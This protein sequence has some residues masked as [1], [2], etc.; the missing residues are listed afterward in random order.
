MAWRAIDRASWP[1]PPIFDWLQRTGNVAEAEMPVSS[2]AVSDDLVVAPDLAESVAFGSRRWAKRCTRSAVSS[3]SGPGNPNRLRMKRLAIL[4]SGRG[5]NMGAILEP[6]KQD[7]STRKSRADQQSARCRWAHGR[8]PARVATAVVDHTRSP[9]RDDFERALGTAIDALAPDLVV[10]AGF[11][12][13]LS[14]GFVARYERR[15]INIHPSLLP[16][17]PGLGTHRRALEDGI[18]VHGCSVHFVTP[19][20]DHAR[21]WRRPRSRCATTTTR[22]RGARARDE[23]RILVAAIGWFCEGSSGHR[24]TRVRVKDEVA[25]AGTL[26]V[27]ALH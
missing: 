6:S 26:L 23:H 14:P 9:N 18:K 12:R 25:D 17:Y 8:R 5:S 1:R 16:M 22:A 3:G 11:M 15:M 7:A 10:L 19:E 21:S 2:T 13:V 20:V 27:P 4:I 24:G